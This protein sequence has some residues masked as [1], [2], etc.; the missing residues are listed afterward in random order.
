VRSR[1]KGRAS[2]ARRGVDFGV[3]FWPKSGAAVVYAEMHGF[4]AI[5]DNWE[6]FRKSVH[7]WPDFLAFKVGLHAYERRKKGHFSENQSLML[8]VLF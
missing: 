1:E 3:P 4:L 7:M 8:D 2:G 6:N 5:L